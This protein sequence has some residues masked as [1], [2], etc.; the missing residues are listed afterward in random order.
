MAT[1]FAYGQ[2]GSGKTHVSCLCHVR[3][4]CP[5]AVFSIVEL[6]FGLFCIQ[7]MGGDFTG[8]QQNSAKGIYAFAGGKTTVL[9]HSVHFKYPGL[10]CEKLTFNTVF[11]LPAQ[12]VFTYLRHR[13]FASLDLS[14]YV[15]FF[16]IYNGKVR[17][18]SSPPAFMD[19]L[20]D[21]IR[22]KHRTTLNVKCAA[23]FRCLT[24]WIRRQS[25]GFWRMIDSRFRSWAWRRSMC[26]QQ[27]KSSR[28][29]RRAVDAGM[30]WEHVAVW[31]YKLYNVEDWFFWGFRF[32][33]SPV[34][35]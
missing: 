7:T 18:N 8:K 2:T 17:I 28:W 20:I 4:P 24:C 32:L 9:S 10:L 6:I 11:R 22:L 16:E 19:T 23:W 5:E 13:R 35:I 29:Y 25:C 15:S 31:Q 1:C 30:V 26:P 21:L 12:D 3:L 14:V 33:P 27:R 34:T